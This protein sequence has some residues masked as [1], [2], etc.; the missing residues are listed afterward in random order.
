METPVNWSR[1]ERGGLTMSVRTVVSISFL[2]LAMTVPL[3]AADA[4]GVWRGDVRLPTG[5][6]LPFVARL[7]QTGTTITGT[8]DGIGGGPAV[9]IMDGRIE[10][11]TIRFRGVRDIN[12][13]P[14]TFNYSARYLND[15]TLEF[16]I[17]R[18]DGNAA[19]LTSVTKRSRD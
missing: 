10:R 3:L 6:M 16:T 19:P 12:G 15:D 9:E 18:D 7:T 4:T 5:Q 14:V 1:P 8:L 11:D 17:V 13:E 2:L